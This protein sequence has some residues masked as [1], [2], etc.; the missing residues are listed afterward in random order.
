MPRKSSEYLHIVLSPRELQ[1]PEVLKQYLFKNCTEYILSTELGTNGHPHLE[2]YARFK[3]SKGNDNVKRAILKL[4]PDIPKEEHRNVSVT[5]NTIDDDPAYGYGYS[6]K[7]GNVYASTFDEFD[8]AEFLEYYEKHRERVDEAKRE[9]KK[10]KPKFISEID[11]IVSECSEFISR[12]FQ[13]STVGKFDPDAPLQW[14]ID[15]YLIPL[16]KEK[17]V[18]FSLYQKINRDKLEEFIRLSLRS[19]LL[20]DLSTTSTHPPPKTKD[21]HINPCENNPLI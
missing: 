8:H 12:Y 16:I 11:Q 2:C 3:S 4:Y 7:E 15:E 21:V 1:D 18:M 13:L 14:L 19:A 10:N 5:I 17:R 9:T 6:L 20:T